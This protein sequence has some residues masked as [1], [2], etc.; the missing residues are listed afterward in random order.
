MRLSAHRAI[1]RLNR[2]RF[3]ES[4]AAVASEADVESEA[5][6]CCAHLHSALSQTAV[7]QELLLLKSHLKVRHFF[8]ASRIGKDVVHILSH[9]DASCVHVRSGLDKAEYELLWG[10]LG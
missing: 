7:E 6:A 2:R 8:L 3:V 5:G 1:A 9:L 10:H 4:E